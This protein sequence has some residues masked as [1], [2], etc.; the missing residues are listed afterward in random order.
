M[1]PISC[2]SGVDMRVVGTH[3][4]QQTG[5]LACDRR[6]PEAMKFS[7]VN[8]RRLLKLRER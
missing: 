2:I 7:N 5:A 8:T 6:F 3:L 4:A 1:P